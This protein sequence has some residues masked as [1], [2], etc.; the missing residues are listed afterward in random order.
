MPTLK[1]PTLFLN[2]E[3]GHEKSPILV[4]YVLFQNNKFLRLNSN[5][6]LHVFLPIIYSHFIILVFSCWEEMEALCWN[7]D[8]GFRRCFENLFLRSVAYNKDQSID[9]IDSLQF[10]PGIIRLA[11]EYMYKY[12]P[13]KLRLPMKHWD[14]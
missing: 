6:L 12:T 8:Y 13:K 14:V 9:S 10:S 3:V 1:Y 11:Y 4:V 7:F 5:S 2:L